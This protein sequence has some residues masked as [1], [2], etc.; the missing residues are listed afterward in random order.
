M[1]APSSRTGRVP[2][3]VFSSNATALS[4]MSSGSA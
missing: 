3:S 4:A 1:L 2:A